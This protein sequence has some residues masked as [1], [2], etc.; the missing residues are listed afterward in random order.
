MNTFSAM[1]VIA[2]GLTAQRTRLNVVSGNLAN[3]QTT[4][5]AQ[6]GP[7]KRKDP[8]FQSSEVQYQKEFADVFEEESDPLAQTVQ[9][10]EVVGIQADNAPPRM[11]YNPDHP[12]ANAK[13]Y[14]AMPNVNVVEEMV[15]MISASRSYEAGVTMMQSVKGM[16]RKAISIGR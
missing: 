2:S 3:A 14:V 1:E 6:G 16:A 11:E 7:Y 13:G 15:N 9:G 8:V 4:R 12:D 10:V 5:T